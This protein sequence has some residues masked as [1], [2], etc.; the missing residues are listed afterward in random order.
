MDESK[1]DVTERLRREG[2]WSEASKF[3]DETVKKLRAE[4]MKRPEAGEQA[5]ETMAKACPPIDPEAQMVEEATR[6]LRGR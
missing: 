6:Q 1:I 3:K 5:R 4:G 2:R